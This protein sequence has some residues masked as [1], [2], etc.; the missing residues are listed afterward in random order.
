[1]NLEKSEMVHAQLNFCHI[2]RNYIG[3]LKKST[4]IEF[5][6]FPLA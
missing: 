1:M 2:E 5:P 3:L 6:S 4:Y